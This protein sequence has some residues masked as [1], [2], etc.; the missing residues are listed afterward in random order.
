MK[1]ATRGT[2]AVSHFRSPDASTLFS[3]WEDGE[4]RTRFEGV[5]HREG[6]T[7]DEL[8]DLMLHVGCDSP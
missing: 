4:L 3:W 8:V 2:L 7:P 5:L 6:T 1:D